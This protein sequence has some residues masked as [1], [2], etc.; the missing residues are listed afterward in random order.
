MHP[1][2]DTSKFSHLTEEEMQMAVLEEE[3]PLEGT[4]TTEGIL[5]IL[6]ITIFVNHINVVLTLAWMTFAEAAATIEGETSSHIDEMM[7]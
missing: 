3:L 1:A 7:S 5:S 2:P 6:L 4:A